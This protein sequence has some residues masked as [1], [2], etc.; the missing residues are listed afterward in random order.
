MAMGKRDLASKIWLSDKRRYAD[1][2]NG[3]VFRGRQIVRPEDLEPI[4]SEADV[5]L[6]DKNGNNKGGAALSGYCHKLEMQSE[7]GG[8]CLRKSE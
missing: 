3:T 2:F 4:N 5:I 6:T 8:V 7:F 1:L